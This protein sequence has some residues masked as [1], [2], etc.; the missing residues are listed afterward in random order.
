MKV[1]FLGTNGWYPSN[2]N[3]TVCTVIVAS[4]RLIALDAG[5][6]FWKVPLLLNKFR[7]KR[8]DVFISHLHLDHIIGLHSLCKIE[9]D[10]G[11]TNIRLIINSYYSSLL[12]KFLSHPFTLDPWSFKL[13]KVSL[14]GIQEGQSRLPYQVVSLPMVH[15][16]PCWGFRIFIDDFTI[17]YC[18]DT[19]RNNNLLALSKNADLLI[20]ECSLLPGSVTMPEWPHMSPEVAAQCAKDANAKQLVLTHFGADV[21]LTLADR[22]KALSTAKKIFPSTI[23]AIDGLELDVKKS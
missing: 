1:F 14:M 4:D 3:N 2:G 5:D 12:R 17:S 21:Y 11:A 13:S 15:A 16:D 10:C 8:L 19:G 18:T 22:K 23:C 20:T 6:G 7:K 9:R